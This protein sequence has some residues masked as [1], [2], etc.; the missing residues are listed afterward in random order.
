MHK[1][2]DLFPVEKS[3]KKFV[4][5]EIHTGPFAQDAQLGSEQV[6]QERLPSEEFRKKFG[7]Q[8]VQ[9]GPFEQF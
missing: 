2:H 9:M 8:P 1:A 3:I 4:S 5:Q 6:T 7:W